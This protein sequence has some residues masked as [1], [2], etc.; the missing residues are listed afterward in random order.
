MDKKA[1][2]ISQYLKSVNLFNEI[3]KQPKNYGT[4]QLIYNSEIDTITIIGQ[5][6][7][8]NLTQIAKNLGISKSGSSR[9]VKKLLEKELI[10]K[11]KK[12]G[13]EKEVIFSLTDKGRI[14]YKEKEEFNKEMY[15]SLYGI[16]SRYVEC[17]LNRIYEF[18]NEINEEMRKLL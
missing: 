9:F 6:K 10:T 14:A 18:L 17:D 12:E 2:I 13:N 1:A 4:D 15:G 11:S 7:T 5:A 16:I 8:I 3:E